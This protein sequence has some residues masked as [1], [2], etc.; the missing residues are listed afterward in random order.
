MNTYR[1][2]NCNKAC[3]SATDLEHMR[4]RRCPYCGSADIQEE[5]TEVT[6]CSED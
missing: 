1:C 4:D 6:S 3:Y 5:K 2:P